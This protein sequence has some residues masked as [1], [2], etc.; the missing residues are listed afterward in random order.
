M[1]LGFTHASYRILL[2][3][4]LNAGYLPAAFGDGERLL[5]D[6]VRFVLL[7]H[8]IDFDLAP[9]LAMARIEAEMGIFS[10]W[11]VLVRTEHYNLF[12]AEGS[13]I[14]AE[15]LGMGHRLGLHFDCAA[16]P[17]AT[18]QELNAGCAKETG[19]LEEWFGVEMPV[20]SIHRPPV[21]VIGNAESLT[22]P[23]LH[24]YLPLFTRRIH[25]LADSR[26]LWRYG[27]PLDSPAFLAGKPLHLLIHPIWWRENATTPAATLN[28]FIQRRNREIELS[29]A[30]NSTVY[31][32][33]N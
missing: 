16:Y 22:A 14:V 19:L 7:R 15:I 10:T 18:V 21:F 12:S 29:V 23:R 9:A 24:T 26:G 5:A 6:G 33:G 31:Q 32:P 20:V 17:G 13:R 2:S 30:A 11:F 4:L 25:Y 8:D 1:G 28:D 3:R 27:E